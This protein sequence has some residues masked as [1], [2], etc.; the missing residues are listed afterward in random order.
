MAYIM[1]VL[2]IKLPF[3]LHNIITAQYSV[4]LFI[5]AVMKLLEDYIN[6]YICII[7]TLS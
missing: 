5:V 3:I 4:S 7:M 2:N 6:C 1:S